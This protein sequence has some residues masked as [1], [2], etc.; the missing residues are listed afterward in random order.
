MAYAIS[1]LGLIAVS[2]LKMPTLIFFIF[3]AISAWVFLAATARRA[4]DIGQNIIPYIVLAFIPY[5]NIISML[6]LLF[7]PS[8][9]RQ[10]QNRVVRKV[11][12]THKKSYK[13]Y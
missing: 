10:L 8:K 6:I 3:V 1:A 11:R 13:S 9:N 4:R 5:I 12:K 2:T 7:T